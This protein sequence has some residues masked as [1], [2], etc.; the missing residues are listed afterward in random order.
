[1]PKLDALKLDNFKLDGA[2]GRPF[3]SIQYGSVTINNPNATGTATIN[4][5][6][7]NKAVLIFLGCTSTGTATEL[8]NLAYIG[9]TDSTTVTATRQASGTY[10][11]TTI[12]NFAVIELSGIKSIQQGTITLN[13]VATNTATVNEVNADKAWLVYEGVSSTNSLADMCRLA[14]TNATTITATRIATSNSSAIGYML[15]EFE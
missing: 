2:V 14:L 5:V 9:L 15:V 7:T 13:G 1:M 12:V 3:V 11:D 10:S 6:D 8:S 4:A